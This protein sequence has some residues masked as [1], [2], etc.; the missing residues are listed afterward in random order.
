MRIILSC[1][2][3]NN[4]PWKRRKRGA[5]GFVFFLSVGVNTRG[6]CGRHLFPDIV[7]SPFF[8]RRVHHL[9]ICRFDAVI[10]GGGKQCDGSWAEEGRRG[11]VI[12]KLN[13]NKKYVSDQTMGRHNFDCKNHYY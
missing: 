7:S 4:T 10:L 3:K 2:Y 5:G 12:I 11:E 8:S 6:A 1:G 13:E 9:R